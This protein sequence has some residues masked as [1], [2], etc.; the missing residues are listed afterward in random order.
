MWKRLSLPLFMMFVTAGCAERQTA[1]PATSEKSYDHP[2]ASKPL[3]IGTIRF[4]KETIERRNS[5]TLD[6]LIR[7]SSSDYHPYFIKAQVANVSLAFNEVLQSVPLE[8]RPEF[9]AVMIGTHQAAVHYWRDDTMRMS[10]TP[11]FVKNRFLAWPIT[12]VPFRSGRNY[13]EALDFEM[14]CELFAR[15]YDGKMSDAEAASILDGYLERKAIARENEKNT[16]IFSVNSM[17]APDNQTTGKKYWL[18]ARVY[19]E[20]RESIQAQHFETLVVSFL[21]EHGWKKVK[22]KDEADIFIDVSSGIIHPR[23]TMRLQTESG[24]H[25][26]VEDG[27]FIVLDSYAGSSFFHLS[28]TARED[29]SFSAKE[30]WKVESRTGIGK[31]GS[32]ELMGG[33][34]IS[35]REFIGR[36][37]EKSQT[38]R[39]TRSKIDFF[40]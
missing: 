11:P 9:L 17:S 20:N 29:D 3:D 27:S 13:R 31:G 16:F 40:E 14:F 22:A 34:L 26:L 37:M 5:D 7:V 25:I 2:F 28:M 24:E 32:M 18:N 12:D 36:H 19:G 10:E 6:N 35:I 21:S 15:H 30:L 33:A 23:T 4:A 8:K 1:I 39:V 38:V